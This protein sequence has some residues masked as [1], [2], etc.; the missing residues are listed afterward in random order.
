MAVA[1]EQLRLGTPKARWALASV[2]LGSGAA[3]VEGSVV[4]IALPSLGRDLGLEISGL[5]WVVNS[6]LLA[7]SALIVL[8]GALGD[9]YG[10]RRVFEAGLAGFAV[11][12]LLCAAA[13]TLEVLIV[14]RILQGVAGAALVPASLA[15][16]EASFAPQDRAA[17]IGTWAGFSGITSAIGPFLGGALVDAGSWRLVFLIV[18]LLALPAIWLARRSLPDSR[19]PAAAGV[20][21]DWL[22]AALI[23][24]ALAGLVYGLV[25]AGAGG[26]RQPRVAATLTGGVV[27]LLAFV[28]V[29][30]R[31]AH[32]MLPLSVFKS[33]QFSGA[34]LATLAN[35]FALGG[36]FFLLSLQLQDV[37]GYSALGAG[38]ASFPF[39]LVMLLFSAR[40]GRLAQRVGARLPMTVGPLLAAAGL[41]LLGR[42]QP[43]TAYLTGVLPPLLL[44]AAGVTTFVA[45]LTAAVLG[46]VP[47]D[48]AGLASAVNNAVSRTAQ[49]LSAAVLPL[50][51]GLTAAGSAAAFGVGFQRAMW[52]SA[53]VAVLGGVLAFATIDRTCPTPAHAHPSHTHGCVET[54]KQPELAAGQAG[55][56]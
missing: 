50:A 15:I 29:E 10:R 43:G 31:V 51:A 19:D 11:A 52:I 25:E 7:L 12:S 8:G 5:Q 46:A 45:P 14:A 48:Q 49:L 44:F 54:R 1:Q 33:R 3:F 41:L 18:V 56:G 47:D 28:V 37:L 16:I 9:R 4:N 17:A 21:L 23:S 35:Y 30:L 6:Y 55:A 53:G 39:T 27:L 34:N 20:R 22:G 38:A 42:V 2:V 32:P 36:S 40:A 24:L 26:L 13:P